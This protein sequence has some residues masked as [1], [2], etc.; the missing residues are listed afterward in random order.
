LDQVHGGLRILW[1]KAGRWLI[2]KHEGGACRQ[3][4][5]HS[6]ALLL[7]NR[8]PVHLSVRVSNSKRGEQGAR[9]MFVFGHWHRTKHQRCQ[10]ILKRR[11]SV[12]Q[13]EGLEDHS[14][15]ASARFVSRCPAQGVHANAG[16]FDRSTSRFAQPSNH[17]QQGA[18][19]ASGAADKQHMFASFHL[20]VRH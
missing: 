18:L 11:E 19:A 6:H 7:A 14:N 2:S 12:Q 20:Q 8:K 9:A 13:V 1:V 4:S 16:H 5:R 3:R 15:A 17:L 10:D